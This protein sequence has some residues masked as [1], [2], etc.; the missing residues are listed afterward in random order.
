M[1][2]YVQTDRQKRHTHTNKQ[3]DKQTNKQKEKRLHIKKAKK[4]NR[5]KTKVYET[6]TEETTID[7]SSISLGRNVVYVCTTLKIVYRNRCGERMLTA[8]LEWL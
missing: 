8:R 4:I 7:L 6:K 1:T 5:A 3:T 2:M